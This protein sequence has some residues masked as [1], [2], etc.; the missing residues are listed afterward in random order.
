[1]IFAWIFKMKRG[2][3]EMHR[4]ADIRV[5]RLFYYL[6]LYITPVCLLIILGFWFKDAI[7]KGTLIPQPKLSYAVVDL[8]NYKGKFEAPA[9]GTDVDPEVEAAN[10]KRLETLTEEI[11]RAAE[12]E[13]RDLKLWADVSI[14]AN[15][16]SLSV[17]RVHGDPALERVLTS[18]KL[19]SFIS[20]KG[21][22]YQR[23]MGE[24]KTEKLEPA[25]N[26]VTVALQVLYTKPYIWMTRV[27]I[28]AITLMFI[29]C[30]R[31]LWKARADS[32]ENA[33]E[34]ETNLEGV[35]L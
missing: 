9:P 4:G 35:Q 8:G 18:E 27:L 34:P 23:R 31:T 24:G 3:E 15:G 10:K 25:A 6:T 21:F 33:S 32:G 20:L 28:V 22:G 14:A 26:Q 1:V 30:I 7:V 29:G 19:R 11:K 17:T 2:W 16:K 13:T 5:P 12:K